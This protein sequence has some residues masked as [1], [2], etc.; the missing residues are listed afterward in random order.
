MWEAR[1]GE[2]FRGYLFSARGEAISFRPMLDD[3]RHLT[4]RIPDELDDVA[5]HAEAVLR[6]RYQ[7]NLSHPARIN[8]QAVPL[9]GHGHARA[10]PGRIVGSHVLTEDVLGNRKLLLAFAHQVRL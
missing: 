7:G 9:Q 1:S 8:H 10:G 3:S 6:D 5:F 4:L 2:P